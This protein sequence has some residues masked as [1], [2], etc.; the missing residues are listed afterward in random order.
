MR[1]ARCD[2]TGDPVAAAAHAHDAAHPLCNTCGHSLT[3]TE[4]TYCDTCIT[5]T[6]NTLTGIVETYTLLEV[7]LRAL[8]H[9]RPYNTAP[10][11]S[12]DT[13]LLTPLVM[14]SPGNTATAAPAASGDRTHAADNHPDDPP[15]VAALLGAW[16]DDWRTLRGEPAN[17]APAT[18]TTAAGYLTTHLRWAADNHPAFDEFTADLH[19]LHTTLQAV[20]G[21][22]DWP[23]TGVP[24]FSCGTDLVRTYTAEKPCSHGPRPGYTRQRVVATGVDG[25]TR[26]WVEHPDTAAARW[27]TE[28]AAWE[29]AHTTCRQGGL[30]DD[31]TCTRCGRTYTEAEYRLAV[32]AQLENGQATG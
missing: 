15:A 12:S 30:T 3:L 25:T 31:Y 32:R 14:R 10:A 1:C 24:C 8:P 19:R 27:R 18:V 29:A 6:R 11:R 23:E 4:H 22:A 21:T 17:P 9:N 20:T 26:T 7:P 2:F 28:L 5:R 16:E 13:S